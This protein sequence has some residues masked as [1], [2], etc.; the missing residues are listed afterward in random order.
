MD[1]PQPCL[2]PQHEQ[3][4]ATKADALQV[5]GMPVLLEAKPLVEIDQPRATQGD[6]QFGSIAQ[7]LGTPTKYIE[8]G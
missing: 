7:R 2:I 5:G 6:E 8:S 1:G 3:Q 4:G